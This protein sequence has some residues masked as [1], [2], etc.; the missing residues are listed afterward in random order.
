MS[1]SSPSPSS[2]WR[3]VMRGCLLVLLLLL[4]VG[5]EVGRDGLRVGHRARRVVAALLLLLLMMWMRWVL[6]VLLM[7]LVMMQ[8]HAWR[9]IIWWPRPRPGSRI[10]TRI[11]NRRPSHPHPSLPP[12]KPSHPPP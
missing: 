3:V 11:C 2:L 4:V 12:Y 1:G 10:H 5:R 7:L 6:L 8:M 9:V